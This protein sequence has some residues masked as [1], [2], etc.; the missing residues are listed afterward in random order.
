MNLSLF[1]LQASAAERRAPEIPPPGEKIRVIIDTDAAC[2]ID[3]QYAIALAILSQE[4]FE[5]EGFV[6][7]HFG[8]AGGADG[9]EKS[10]QVIQHVLEK[11]GFD[12]R[13]P[14]KRGSDPFQYSKVPAESEGVDFI[15]ECAFAPEED[16]PLWIISLGACTDVASAYLK[17]PEIAEK[18]IVFWHGRTRWPDKAWNFNVYNDLKAAR[19]LFS[20]DLPLVLFDT[21]TYLRCPMEESKAR[22]RPHGEL[23][24]YLHDF[25]LTKPYYQSP[26]K[27]FFDLGDVAALVDPSL[28]YWEVVDVPG[29]N[30]D[31]AYDRSKSFGSMVRIY[32]IDRDRTFELLYRKLA[33]SQ[34]LE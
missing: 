17:R 4:R 25:R 9:I 24:R 18:V 28:V 12:D 23:G 13:F 31:M 33:E 16:R 15:L 10:A 5:I 14:V 27:G 32:Q 21:G 3:D 29:I 2:E 19:V 6:A 22:I 7:A 8:D 26:R 20:S 1:G 34:R 30:W 11:A